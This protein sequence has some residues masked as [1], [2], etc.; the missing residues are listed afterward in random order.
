MPRYVLLWVETGSRASGSS[1]R[2]RPKY[3]C[4]SVLSGDIALSG[5][6]PAYAR[7][8]PPLVP[9]RHHG[10][11]VPSPRGLR[12]FRPLTRARPNARTAA[13][14]WEGRRHPGRTDLA[15]PDRSST[16]PP[17]T[18]NP[19]PREGAAS[20]RGRPW[21]RKLWHVTGTGQRG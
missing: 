13:A 16:L 5:H 10:A 18:D 21:K 15:F 7:L 20:A 4:S 11:R 17:G 12:H 6:A 2:G 1:P 3:P 19:S 9:A 14:G 8:P